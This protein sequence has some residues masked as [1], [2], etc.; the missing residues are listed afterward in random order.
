MTALILAAVLAAD[1]PSCPSNEDKPDVEQLVKHTEQLLQGKS[2]IAV[3]TM[4]IKTPSWSRKLKMK[5]WSKGQDFALIRVL[6][7][8]PHEAGM[9]TLKREKQLWNYLPQAGRVMKLPSGMLGDSWMGSDFTN[10]DLVKGSSLTKDFTSTVDST[11]DLAGKK[12]WH[13]TLTPKKDAVVVWGKIQM[14]VD[15]ASCVPVEEKFFDEDGKPV[16]TMAF[17]D[18]KDVGWRH[19]PQKMTVTP[20][21]AGRETAITYE[22]IEFDPEISEDTFSLHRLQQEH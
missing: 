20:A 10:D 1:A 15:R 3:M 2:S 12:A 11:V 14:L 8:G 21:E 6:E 18:F 16:R 22:S 7:G 19:F 13:I 17:S 5:I 9:M 4:A